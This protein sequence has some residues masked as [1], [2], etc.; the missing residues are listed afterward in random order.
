MQ[1]KRNID[2]DDELDPEEEKPLFPC[3]AK[4]IKPM[5]W[6][7]LVAVLVII[8]FV[9]FS[10][11]PP[12]TG[13]IG[14]GLYHWEQGFEMLPR[15]PKNQRNTL[16]PKSGSP[17]GWYYAGKNHACLNCGWKGSR[18]GVDAYGNHICP[19]CGYCPYAKNVPTGQGV[20]TV[21][22]A[23]PTPT[24]VSKLGMEV[25][26]TQRGVMAS[27]VY[28]NSTAERGGLQQGDVI[29]KFN[30]RKVR[31]V[32][33]F[34]QAV[35]AV[36]PEKRVR[37]KVYRIGEKKKLT[38]MVGEGEM[39]GVIMGDNIHPAGAQAAVITRNGGDPMGGYG[40]G[41]GGYVVCPDCGF[42]MLHQRGVPAYTL[43]CPKCDAAMVREQ[44]LQMA[45]MPQGNGVAMKRGQG[46]N[47]WFPKR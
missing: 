36:P 15:I 27:S 4:I 40:F 30:H 13:Q 16:K 18:L 41:P 8:G 19:N 20:A 26:N 2:L 23:S 38:V 46:L 44:V 10:K 32:I 33:E 22:T 3:S 5:A 42:K 1:Y 47:P 17:A 29:V 21:T 7:L 39:E 35:A 28:G 14:E 25:I 11:K 43:N 31:N 34:K 37:V 45:G 24:L 12:T 6:G 9:V